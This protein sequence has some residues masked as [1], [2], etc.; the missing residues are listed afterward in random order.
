MKL[1]PSTPA[2][3]KIYYVAK[4]F[5]DHNGKSTSKNVAR[6]GTFEEIRTRENVKDAFAWCKEKVRRMNEDE[7]AGRMTVNAQY[8]PTKLVDKGVQPSFNLGY[9]LLQRVYHELGIDRICEGMQRKSQSRYDLNEIMQQLVFLRV[10]WPRSKKATVELAATL[11]M[12]TPVNLFSVYRALLEIEE[13]MDY[14][15]ERLYHYSQKRMDRDTSVIYYDCTNFFFESTTETPLRKPGASKENRRTP[16]VQMG[17]FMDADGLPLAFNVNPGNTNEQV[18]LK[19]LEETIG[20]K[21]GIE[22]FVMCTDAGLGSFNNKNYNDI[23][24]R[25]FITAQSVKTLPDKVKD[26]RAV[27]IKTWALDTEGWSL[28][29]GGDGYSIKGLDMEKDLDKVFFKERWMIVKNQQTGEELSQRLIVTFSLKY[30]L[31]Q[32][33]RR[34]TNIDRAQKAIE[35]GNAGFSPKDFKSMIKKVSCTADGEVADKEV[36]DLDW[37]HIREEER[38]DGFY[39]TVTNLEEYR[40]KEGVRHNT[41]AHIA[42]INRA[43]WEIEYLFRILKSQFKTRPVYLREDR[44]VKA[45]MCVCF[46]ALFVFRVL[47]KKLPGFTTDEI[48]DTLRNMNGTLLKGQGYV[49]GFKRTDLTDAMF[50]KVGF[51]LDTEIVTLKKVKSIIM[52]NKGR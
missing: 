35:H 39:A 3:G 26:D 17:I 21:M 31:Y 22:Q 29:G 43:R 46:L 18:T 19:P 7:R 11:A 23:E 14:I 12:V 27:G 9:L 51:R 13:N 25:K 50:E 40:D 47:E 45:H 6:L 24:G 49:N 8:S 32:R 28:L 33:D 20:K 52:S 38:Y 34:Q 44:K 42:E 37:E 41:A 48:L 30:F 15:Q 16:I 5:R 1:V 4:S 10:L 36:Y 2:E